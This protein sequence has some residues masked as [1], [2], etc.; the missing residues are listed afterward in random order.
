MLIQ[1]DENTNTIFLHDGYK[2]QHRMLLAL[3]IIN[4]IMEL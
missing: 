2:V 1:Y 3:I 4:A